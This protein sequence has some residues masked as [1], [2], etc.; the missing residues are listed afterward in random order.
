MHN[1]KV[2][3]KLDLVMQYMFQ[4]TSRPQKLMRRV[5]DISRY[6]SELVNAVVLH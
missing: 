5:V 6:R 1:H 2:L 4:L 3:D